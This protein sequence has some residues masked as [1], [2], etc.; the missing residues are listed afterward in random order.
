[1]IVSFAFVFKANQ[2]ASNSCEEHFRESASL[3]A[4]AFPLSEIFRCGFWTRNCSLYDLRI[5]LNG[6]SLCFKWVDLDFR[7]RVIRIL[8]NIPLHR[9]INKFWE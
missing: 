1:L 6:K 7:I 8:E 4:N 3:L 9:L 2:H 5:P